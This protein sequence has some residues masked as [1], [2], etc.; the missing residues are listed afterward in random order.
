ML[1]SLIIFAQASA[2]TAGQAAAPAAPVA[3]ARTLQG[4]PNTAIEYY[5]VAGKDIKSLQSSIASV[6]GNSAANKPAAPA[7]AAWTVGSKISRQTTDGKCAVAGAEMKFDAKVVLPRLANREQ[8]PT[9]V[10]TEWDSFVARLEA[11]TASNLWFV[12]DRIG[13]IQS[14]ILT[15]SCEGASAA[16][17]AAVDKLQKEEAEFLLRA[18]TAAAAARAGPKPD[19]P[20][21][22]VESVKQPVSY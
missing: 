3:A 2:L 8:V 18:A 5:D 9:K 20:P 4:L 6:R 11:G 7:S 21:T 12:H 14:A 13:T 1:T 15:S 10:L 19:Q 22:S 17:T 16:A